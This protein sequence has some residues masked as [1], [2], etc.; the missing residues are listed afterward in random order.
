MALYALE[1]AQKVKADLLLCNIYTVPAAERSPGRPKW[2]LSPHNENSID[3]LGGVV[4]HLLKIVDASPDSVFKPEIDQCSSEGGLKTTVNDLVSSH[5]VFMVIIGMHSPG[6]ASLHVL[7][8]HAW[9]VIEKA[10]FPVL[11]VP[12][13]VKFK[14]YRT[15]AFATDLSYTDKYVLKSLSGL[16]KYSEADILLTYVANNR[17]YSHDLQDYT[18]ELF[19]NLAPARHDP[20]ILFRAIKNESVTAGLKE[21]LLDTK[22]DMLVLIKRHHNSFK[23]FFGQNVV[24]R[25]STFPAKPLLI[26]PDTN[27]MERLPVF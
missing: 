15:I 16:A 7:S 4:A 11:V 10:D 22:I 5:H 20:H 17:F 2:P 25:L 9:Q 18:K 13:Q 6:A 21:L 8:D 27:F 24:R 1:F 26:F 19:V 12:C 14:D 3:D 23:K